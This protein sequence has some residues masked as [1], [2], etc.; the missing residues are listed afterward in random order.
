MFKQ[1]EV[2]VNQRVNTKSYSSLHALVN[3]MFPL[4][5]SEEQVCNFVLKYPSLSTPSRAL[6]T[7]FSFVN[8]SSP[9]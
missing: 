6:H 9:N 1:G 4:T 2:A 3:E 8:S 7:S 5:S